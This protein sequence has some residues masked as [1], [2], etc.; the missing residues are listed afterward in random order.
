[1]HAFTPRGRGWERSWGVFTPLY[2]LHSEQ[3]W[4]AGDFRDLQAFNEW[5]RELGANFVGTLPLLPVFMDE[6]YEISPYSPV[7]RLFWNEF[8]LHL[9]QIPELAISA[10]ARGLIESVEVSTEIDSLR[11]ASLVDY[12][13]QMALK[14]RV[15]EILARSFFASDSD[16]RSVFNKYL[17]RNSRLEDYATFRAI[18]E[19]LKRPWSE[20]PQHLQA[21]D[22]SGTACCQQSKLYHMYVQWLAEEQIQ[23]AA[24]PEG[25]GGLYLDLPLGVHRDGYDVWR[26]RES[27]AIGVAG[28]CP[29]DIVFPDGQNWGF[30]PL[31]PEG[32]RNTAYRYV[33]AYLQHQLRLAKILRI[34][35]MP[36]FHRVFW[37][38][39]GRPASE[40]VYVRYH[41][42]EL[43]ALFCLE[44]HRHR[45]MLVGEDLGTVP[46]EVP[47]AMARHSFHRMHVVQYE[48]QPEAEAALPD[49]PAASIAMLNTHDMPPFAGFWHDCDLEERHQAG[50]LPADQ[51]D[52][53]HV[54][55][56][57][58]R[59]S[60]HQYLESRGL[61]SADAGVKDIMLACM[62]HLRDGPAR[63]FL[64]NLE[65]LWQ[66]TRSQNIPSTSGENSNWRRKCRLTFEE[67]SADREIREMLNEVRKGFD[68]RSDG[69]NGAN[70]DK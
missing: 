51:L 18:G 35:H 39:P 41:A 60:L 54:A 67:L 6:N 46:P 61:V 32:V 28:G 42:D 17:T 44:S 13:R 12:R 27:F 30:V 1:M 47:A 59:K 3:S 21:G 38:P 16:R 31:H 68:S 2:S 22:L 8:Y 52:D 26:E 56:S 23:T 24:K 7:S 69:G 48:L 33:R 57:Q 50:L 70:G 58:L 53:E 49:P 14:R 4:G 66:E 15:L 62:A 5:A 43:Y 64:L 45:T 34:D 10:E 40:G 65:D 63:M 29:P 36:S 37:I 19:Q 20:W 9:P 25:V 55:R 11:A